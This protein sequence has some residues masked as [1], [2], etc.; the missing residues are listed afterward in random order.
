[1]TAWR[2]IAGGAEGELDVGLDSWRQA[3]GIGLLGLGLQEAVLP[4]AV[5]VAAAAATAAG[6][7]IRVTTP[8]V[9]VGE[10]AVL[11]R[12]LNTWKKS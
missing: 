7:E 5:G 6:A 3:G 1:M 4:A 10:G 8:H 12:S 11:A 9:Q 2:R